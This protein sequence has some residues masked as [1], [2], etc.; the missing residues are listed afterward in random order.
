MGAPSERVQT[1]AGWG[2]HAD[3]PSIVLLRMHACTVQAARGPG[4]CFQKRK[5]YDV[6]NR[7]LKTLLAR[8]R[9]LAS[10]CSGSKWSWAAQLQR[11]SRREHGDRRMRLSSSV[12]ENRIV[13]R[14]NRTEHTVRFDSW[15]QKLKANGDLVKKSKFQ[16][17]IPASAW[18]LKSRRNKKRIATAVCKWRG[19]SNEPN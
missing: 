9:V 4:C 5:N 11:E 1:L 15:C 2:A 12:V 6:W 7:L 17:K 14:I 16:K 8:A 13:G 18:R 3:M 19:E 10:P